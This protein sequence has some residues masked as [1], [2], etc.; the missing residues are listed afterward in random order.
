VL[1]PAQTTVFWCLQ[2]RQQ[3]FDQQQ[4]AEAT[5][6]SSTYP[7]M[8]AA[9]LLEGWT[10]VAEQLATGTDS[11]S[12]RKGGNSNSNSSRPWPCFDACKPHQ[13]HQQQQQ[14]SVGHALLEAVA[15]WTGEQR[16]SAAAAA[17]LWLAELARGQQLL[18]A[19]LQ[20]AEQAEMELSALKLDRAAD[21]ET[22]C[23]AD[24][25]AASAAM[26]ASARGL[27]G[28]RGGSGSSSP[29]QLGWQP[30]SAFA[31]TV[32]AANDE[33]LRR[34]LLAAQQE[35]MAARAE[36]MAARYA[37]G[38]GQAGF[39]S[40]TEDVQTLSIGSP[41]LIG[42]CITVRPSSVGVSRFVNGKE[43]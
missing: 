7:L 19:A 17:A 20:R 5:A 24:T 8:R 21:H 4:Q 29:R 33:E 37:Q 14:R 2:C 16:A 18:A 23:L 39:E 40:G 32:A 27:P 41:S 15:E 25:P 43:E 6:I 1:L 11:K 13:Q 9:Q 30:G 12:P 26:V 42:F 35:L 10:A 38:G 22:L 28:S 36:L 31:A 3:C 34:Q